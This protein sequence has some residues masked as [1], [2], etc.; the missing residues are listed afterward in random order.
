M[1]K[2]IKMLI[3]RKI[4][5]RLKILNES[6]I[7]RKSNNMRRFFKNILTITG[8]NDLINDATKIVDDHENELLHPE[9]KIYLEKNGL[10][11]YK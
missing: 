6:E 9:I 7:K 1:K 4:I 10:D 11:Q 5:N 2:I 8:N 3:I